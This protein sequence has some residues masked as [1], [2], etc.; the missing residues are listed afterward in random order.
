MRTS[1]SSTR[2]ALVAVTALAGALTLRAQTTDVALLLTHVGERVSDYYRRAQNIICTEKVVA[3]QIDSSWNADGFS[4]SL[5]YELH[6]ES[7]GLDGDGTARDA[8][9]A[10]E[11]RKVNGRAPRPTDTEGCFDPETIEP[12]PLA[13]LLPANQREYKFQSAGFGRGKERNLLLVDF[14][15]T[16]TGTPEIRSDKRKRPE[17][18]QISLPVTRAG[19]LW[20]DATT[21]DVLRVDEHLAHRVDVRVPY[22]QQRHMNLPDN[23]TVERYET[24]T[25]YAVVRFTDPEESLLLP[26]SI[27]EVA[28]MRGAGSHRKRQEFSAYRRFLTG[29]RLVK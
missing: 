17:C 29:G 16:E 23:I 7:E 12:E 4:R 3:Q 20:I 24:T 10:R 8:K 28:I 26:A 22:E 13:F 6:L 14:V 5:E 2:N 27:D 1:A 11:L 19:R 15:H 9:I 18:F 25:R 21:Y